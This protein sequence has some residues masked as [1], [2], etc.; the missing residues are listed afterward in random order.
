M[1]Q[2]E[3]RSLENTNRVGYYASLSLA[4]L[5]AV[6]FAVAI[7]TPPLSGPFCTSSCMQYPYAQ[8][9]WRVPQDFLWM[10]PAL[11]L[12][13][14]YTVFAACIHLRTGA[15]KRIFSLLGLAFGLLCT[16]CL[17][18]DYFVQ[19]FVVQP[20]LLGGEGEGLALLSQYNPHGVFVV[21]EELG[22]L[23]MALSFLGFAAVF[24]QG[25][26]LQ[27]AVRRVFG[28]GFGLMILTL[29]LISLGFGLR[30]EY[31]FECYA[32]LIAYLVLVINGILLSRWFRRV[33]D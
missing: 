16:A 3:D 18:M 29:V 11:L 5:S 14:N 20:S 22:Y 2:V 6:T 17:S 23:L 25:T 13:L 32:I 8:A 27:N 19:L 10:Y 30:R 12:S 15:E 21:L 26:R 24:P 7:S 33:G 4:A 9:A 31:I 1:N 28:G